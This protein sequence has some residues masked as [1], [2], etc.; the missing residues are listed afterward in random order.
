MTDQRVESL[1]KAL[2]RFNGF[3]ECLLAELRLVNYGYSIEIDL[4]L[5]FDDIGSVRSDVLEVSRICTLRLDGVKS[6]ILIG[7]L[8][9]WMVS[10]P[11]DINWGL[12]E[13]AGIEVS[14]GEGITV[15]VAWEGKREVKIE[16]HS[17]T[18]RNP[19]GSSD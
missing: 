16:C 19:E 11:E 4:N 5:V 15:T 14:A 6:M 17:A 3:S 12:S 8:S 7:G 9:D 1:Q 13:I 2:D 18:L 10:H